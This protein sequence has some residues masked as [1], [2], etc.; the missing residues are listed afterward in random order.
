MVTYLITIMSQ[1]SI[2][3]SAIS[4]ITACIIL[5]YYGLDYVDTLQ[6][7]KFLNTFPHALDIISRGLKTGITIEKTFHTIT[8]EIEEPVRGEFQYILDQI[9]FGVPFEQALR[10]SVNRFP[11]NGFHFFVSVLILQRKTGG[12]AAEL[13]AEIARVLRSQEAL[14]DKIRALSAEA[15]TTGWIVGSLPILAFI[16]IN[17]I[18][19]KYL[20]IFQNSPFGHKLLMLAGGLLIASVITIKKMVNFKDF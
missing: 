4:G 1:L 19:P 12:S 7:R 5:S 11:Y 2:L 15:K 10:N 13:I 9:S 6:E 3:T 14:R 18:Q 16:G 8:R 20:E 17:F